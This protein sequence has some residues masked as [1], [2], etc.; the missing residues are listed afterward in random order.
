[1]KKIL[2]LVVFF[3]F[4][5]PMT[6]TLSAN[7]TMEQAV[8]AANQ[9]LDMEYYF[10]PAQIPVN[11][12][13][14][15]M[16]L[17]QEIWNQHKILVYGGPNAVPAGEQDFKLGHYR[18]LGYTPDGDLMPDPDFPSDNEASTLINNWDWVYEPYKQENPRL[19]ARVT[20]WDG[21]SSHLP[22]INDIL[23]TK[24][25][26]LF[27]YN[28][29]KQWHLYTKILQPRTNVTPGLGRLWHNWRGS[30]WYIS[31]LIPAQIPPDIEVVSISN[32]SPVYVGTTQSASVIYRN[33][34]TMTQSF[35]VRFYIDNDVSMTES[36]TLNAGESIN[37]S[38]N[39]TAPDNPGRVLLKAEALPVLEETKIDDNVKTE[40]VEIISG[41]LD[42][43]A[44]ITSA[45]QYAAAGNPVSLK[46]EIKHNKPGTHVNTRVLWKMNGEII[47]DT[48]SFGLLGTYE[49]TVSFNMP[50]RAAN[51]SLT[52]NPDHDRPPDEVNW[53]NNTDSKTISLAGMMPETQDA[54]VQ[55]R[56]EAPDVVGSIKETDR[57]MFT[58]AVVVES[59]SSIDHWESSEDIWTDEDGEEHNSTTWWPVYKVSETVVTSETKGGLLTTKYSPFDTGDRTDI[60]IEMN[61]PMQYFTVQGPSW[62]TKRY[63][64]NHRQV[65][66]VDKDHYVTIIAEATV[67][68]Q[69]ARATKRIRIKGFSPGIVDLQLWE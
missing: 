57:G 22:Y 8:Q 35:D 36:I 25:G 6:V 60:K 34:S 28:D 62:T 10:T 39:W 18:F 15:T 59:T 61:N 5:F 17:N 41:S 40:D 69:T 65:G 23:K 67:E 13:L 52:V 50:P 47:K 16:E 48:Q 37:R 19:C 33:K 4:L 26:G 29:P 32:P 9:E 31:I 24:F 68:N 3:S 27:D 14:I 51:I 56:I 11:G 58:Y 55:V 46:A 43:S 53:S 2:F 21:L 12:N 38:Y 30:L 64:Y 7:L 1:M 49:D 20:D 54:L 66:I 63:E 42:L 45:P 44:H